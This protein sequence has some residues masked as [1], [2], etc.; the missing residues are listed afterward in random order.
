[1]HYRIS[2]S[3]RISSLVPAVALTGCWAAL[4]CLWRV[5]TIAQDIWGA[6]GTTPPLKAG[7][8]ELPGTSLAKIPTKGKRKKTERKKN[9]HGEENLS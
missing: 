1:M 9:R 4:G 7:L 3:P 6:P 8:E 5:E 2:T